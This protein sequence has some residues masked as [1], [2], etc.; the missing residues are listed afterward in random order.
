MI[1]H[2]VSREEVIIL[3]VLQCGDDPQTFGQDMGSYTVGL[4]KID[5]E[6]ISSVI[7]KYKNLM[8][9]YQVKIENVFFVR[10]RSN[11]DVYKDK[12]TLHKAQ[13]REAWYFEKNKEDLSEIPKQCQGSVRLAE[14]LHELLKAALKKLLPDISQRL[15]AKEKQLQEKR[16]VLGDEIEE[17]DKQSQLRRFLEEIFD[18]LNKSINAEPH[19]F[20]LTPTDR[21][22]KQTK[23]INLIFDR[24]IANKKDMPE[25]IASCTGQR[26]RD[27]KKDIVE[28][29][30]DSTFF[31]K[32][33]FNELIEANQKFQNFRHIPSLTSPF[34]MNKKLE[35]LILKFDAPCSSFALWLSLLFKNGIQTNKQQTNKIEIVQRVAQI[36]RSETNHIIEKVLEHYPNLCLAVCG[37]FEACLKKCESMCLSQVRQMIDIELSA[38]YTANSEF[39]TLGR[40]IGQL[41]LPDD[42]KH[43]TSYPSVLKIRCTE[44]CK[45]DFS[46][47]YV[48]EA[49][50]EPPQYYKLSAD[51]TSS[52]NSFI[53]FAQQWYI[54]KDPNKPNVDGNGVI[55]SYDNNINN[56]NLNA[57]TNQLKIKSGQTYQIIKDTK[58]IPI[59]FAPLHN[60][61]D[62]SILFD[63]NIGSNEFE[64]FSNEQ[65][66]VVKESARMFAYWHLLKKRFIDLVCKLVIYHLVQALAQPEN[67]GKLYDEIFGISDVMELM[68]EDYSRTEERKRVIKELEDIDSCHQR[69]YKIAKF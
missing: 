18:Q 52:Q 38:K 17:K 15:E 27:F 19:D 51:G 12:M 28:C 41:L 1:N 42:K 46:G 8:T 16:T 61:R 35:A 37:E 30:C 55:T 39:Y 56:V 22:I 21:S 5:K 59:S 4:S 36:V 2:Y 23:T 57:L 50:S 34:V 26:L 31:E 45:C 53:V 9:S 33:W 7:S 24:Q 49:N 3:N 11:D 54:T 47:V 10:N 69:L 62:K 14:R 20:A 44:E 40:E 6:E 68:K 29:H 64:H 58:I 48:S 63:I 66:E 13:Q 67:K 32:G 25:T 43:A 65:K 60:W